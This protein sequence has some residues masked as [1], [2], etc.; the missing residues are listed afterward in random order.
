LQS[1]GTWQKASFTTYTSYAPCCKSNPNYD[2]KY[3]TEECDDYSAC[4]YP[5]D[6][7]AIGHKSFSWVKSHDL[8]AFYDSSDK[9]G[10]QFDSKYANKQVKLRKNGVELTALI[11]DTCGDWDCDGCCTANAKPSGFLVDM[12]YYT[13]LR[14]FG[15]TDAAEGQ[16]EFMVV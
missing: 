15:S 5:G 8:I 9:K 2:P 13:I 10:K 12:E 11:A 6:F 16:I 7:A 4:D 1:A 14:Y 3:P